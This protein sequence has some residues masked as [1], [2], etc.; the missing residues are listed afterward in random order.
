MKELA[1]LKICKDLRAGQVLCI[2]DMSVVESDSTIGLLKRR[3]YSENRNTMLSSIE[4]YLSKIILDFCSENKITNLLDRKNEI[5]EYLI[6]NALT[7]LKSLLVTYISDAS[8]CDKLN[9]LICKFDK[10]MK[11]CLDIQTAQIENSNKSIYKQ[12]NLNIIE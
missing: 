4:F 3:W 6:Y 8:F 5:D 11:D 1:F 9:R 10:I 12:A 2:S 7:G